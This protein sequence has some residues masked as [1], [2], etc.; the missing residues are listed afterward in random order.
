VP[1][2]ASLLGDQRRQASKIAA[3][4]CIAGERRLFFGVRAGDIAKEENAGVAVR[5]ARWRSVWTA[6]L[7]VRILCV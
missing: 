7:L 6:C 1:S 3:V 5:R 4:L 2:T